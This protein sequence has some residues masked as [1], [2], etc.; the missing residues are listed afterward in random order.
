[1]FAIHLGV[2]EMEEL[3]NRL[4]KKHQSC[5]ATKAEEKAAQA[6]GKSNG[7]VIRESQ[8]SGASFP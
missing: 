1:M 5:T 2:P 8:A 7:A 3:W 6:D 4:E